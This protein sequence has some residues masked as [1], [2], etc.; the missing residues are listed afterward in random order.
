MAG[1]ELKIDARRQKILEI[2]SRDGQVRVSRLSELLDATQVT[3]RSDLSALERDGYLE[4]MQ[5][6]AVQTVKNYYN[7][8][9]QQRK[10]QNSAVKKRLASVVC[11]M[12]RDGDTLM[13]NS[14]TTTYFVAVELKKRKNLNIVTNSLSVAVEMGG[15]PTFRV[16]LLGGDI[17]AQYSFTYGADAQEQLRRYRAD[18]AILSMDGLCPETGLTTYHAEEAVMDLLM[19]ERSE[20]TI[21]A[22]ESRKI[23]REGF[24]RVG[25]AARVNR[26]VTDSGI[27]HELARRLTALGVEIKYC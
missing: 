2:L 5:G 24:S 27:D 8:D 18:Y 23:G 4:R 21:V 20:H 7:L 22:A 1:G 14:G 10:Q 16:I 6:G 3:I 25:D 15:H 11:D 17:N 19:M 13:I 26:L 9:F 12:I